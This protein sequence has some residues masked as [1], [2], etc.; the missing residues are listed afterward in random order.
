MKIQL[1]RSNVLDGGSAKKPTAAQMEFGELAVNYNAAD[2]T[3][4]IKDDSG[5]IIPIAGDSHILNLIQENQQIIVSPTPPTTPPPVVGGLWLDMSKCPPELNVWSDCETTGGEWLPI[6]G[7]VDAIAFTPAITDDGSQSANTPTHVLTADAGTIVGGTAP[8]EYGFVWK[9][10]GTEVGV[11]TK[12]YT[13]QNSDI[14][15]VI[16][17]DVTV[18]EPDGSNPETRTATYSQAIVS[19][20]SIVQPTNSF[21]RGW[22]W[23]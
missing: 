19:G 12:T 5:T 15:N 7:G 14:G 1:K 16:S 18:A 4:F 6:G 2:P 22:C 3:I 13:I 17:C 23:L 21:P 9:S 11:T 20:A 8:I 10:A